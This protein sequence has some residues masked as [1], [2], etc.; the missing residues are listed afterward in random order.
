[1]LNQIPIIEEYLDFFN[2]HRY[3]IHSLFDKIVIYILSNFNLSHDD[4]NIHI[5]FDHMFS[6]EKFT[7][8]MFTLRIGKQGIPIYFKCFYGKRLN[9]NHGEAFKI[10]EV[11]DGIKHC[12][13]LIKNAIPNANIIF[14]AD[15]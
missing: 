2:N 13:D 8:L 1:M 15:R 14:L 4:N 9:E 10:K 3:N 11:K 5:S 12:H 7:I 6:K